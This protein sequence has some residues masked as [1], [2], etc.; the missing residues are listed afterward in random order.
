ME[1]KEMKVNLSDIIV[2]ESLQLRCQT[3]NQA[4]QEYTE[5]IQE[6]EQFPPLLVWRTEDVYVLLDGWHRLEAM[7]A[8]GFVD[9]DCKAFNGSKTEAMIAATLSNRNHGL[10]FSRDDKRKAIARILEV[11]VALSS[12]QV[13]D[14]VGVSSHTVESVREQLGKCNP[15]GKR[16]GKDG[17]QYPATVKREPRFQNGEEGTQDAQGDDN[18]PPPDTGMGGDALKPENIDKAQAP[19]MRT[20][21]ALELLDIAIKDL[22]E[23]GYKGS[24]GGLMRVKNWVKG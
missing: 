12:K 8:C 23:G 17:K 10:P 5:R 2:D 9:Y 4:V 21:E 18:A 19:K 22:L 20:S 7:K 24:A 6:G 11:D 1:T 3:S 13:A 16:K 15:A 14:A